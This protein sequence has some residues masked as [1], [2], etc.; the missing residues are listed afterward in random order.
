M[1]QRSRRSKPAKPSPAQAVTIGSNVRLEPPHSDRSQNEMPTIVE[2]VQEFNPASGF[3]NFLREQAVV[4]LALG[5]II[6]TQAQALVK[7]LVASFIDPLF[8]LLFGQKM[9]TRTFDLTFHERT[10]TFTWGTFVYA[11]INFLFVL[12]AIY[13][14]VKFFKLDKFNKPKDPKK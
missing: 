1:T 6:G 14:V 13:L 10:A 4:G 3:F 12:L 9:T 5:F 8:T 7:Q 2:V 11:F